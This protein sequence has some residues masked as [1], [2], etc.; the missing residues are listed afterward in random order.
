MIDPFQEILFSFASRFRLAILRSNPSTSSLATLR[1][2]PRGACGDASLLLA[3]YLQV[4]RCGQSLYVLGRRRGHVHAWLQLEQFTIDITAD[5]FDDQDAGVIVAPD[6]PW[7][8]SFYGKIHNVADFCLYD[9]DTVFQLTRAYEAITAA[10]L[11]D[12]NRGC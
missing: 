8:A 1:D 2:F 4:N 9:P 11:F 7:H 6:S 10:F 3:K 12:C 5:Q